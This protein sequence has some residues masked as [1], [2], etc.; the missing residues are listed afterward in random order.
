MAT[1]TSSW[2]STIAGS[3]APEIDQVLAHGQCSRRSFRREADGAAS[4]SSP[5]R[6]A[7]HVSG[8]AERD[9]RD[10]APE[11]SPVVANE[12]AAALG[13]RPQAAHRRDPERAGVE[14]DASRVDISAAK[15]PSPPRAMLVREPDHAVAV[16]ACVD[17]VPVRRQRG[18]PVI[19]K[20]P[21]R[22]GQAPEP[23]RPTDEQPARRAQDKLASKRGDCGHRPLPK[24]LLHAACPRPPPSR[25]ERPRSAASCDAAH[26]PRVQIAVEEREREHARVGSGCGPDTRAGHHP[27]SG[28]TLPLPRYLHKRTGKL[29]HRA[30]GLLLHAPPRAEPP[31]ASRVAA[32]GSEEH[33]DGR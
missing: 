24:P 10:V 32:T 17:R 14:C 31:I 25:L 8:S 1:N 6:L 20:Q 11:R 12:L 21:R 9:R 4:R 22:D 16:R 15:S 3:Q 33:A 30:P 19:G 5:R 2:R 18:D 23:S 28:L 7:T 13:T 27:G 26:R 29:V